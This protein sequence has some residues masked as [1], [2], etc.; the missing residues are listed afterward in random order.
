MQTVVAICRHYQLPMLPA[1]VAAGYITTGEAR[2]I[3]SFDIHALTDRELAE[4]ILRRASGNPTSML[5]K[6]VA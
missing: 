5:H 2:A 6:P 1:F 3:S 4:E